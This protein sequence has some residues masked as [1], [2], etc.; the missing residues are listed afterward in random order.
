[1]GSGFGLAAGAFALR[2]QAG[3]GAVHYLGAAGLGAAGGVLLHVL[4]RP[5]EQKTPDRMVHELRS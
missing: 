3:A 2:H 4:T 5:E 1:V